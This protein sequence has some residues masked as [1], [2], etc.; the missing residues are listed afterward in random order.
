M[1]TRSFFVLVGLMLAAVFSQCQ[2]STHPTVAYSTYLS[3]DD[4]TEIVASTADANGYQYVLGWTTAADFPTT[5]NAYRR[6]PSPAAGCNLKTSCQFQTMFVSKFSRDGRSLVYSTF[7]A[8]AAPGSIAI[9][10][11]GNVYGVAQPVSGGD[12]TATPGA[13]QTSCGGSC[14]FLFKLNSSG[15]ALVYSTYLQGANYCSEQVGGGEFGLGISGP[16]VAVN[17]AGQAYVVLTA[18]PGCFTT[19]GAFKPKMLSG[20]NAIVMKFTADGSGVLY[21]TYVGQYNYNANDIGETIAVDSNDHAVIAG[22]TSSADFPT[23]GHAFQRTRKGF[24]DAFVAKLSADGSALLASTLLGGASATVAPDQANPSSVGGS[25]AVDPFNNVYVAGMT[26]T[27][28]FPVS[29]TAPEHTPDPGICGPDNDRGPCGDAFLAKL[30]PDFSQLTYSTFLGGPN[31]EEAF[32][33]VAVDKVGHAFVNGTSE[34]SQVPLVKPTSS[35]GLA[36]L[37]ELNTSGTQFLFSTRY[38]SAN[39]LPRGIGVDLASN[40]Y[41]GG[42]QAASDLPTTAHAYQTTDMSATGRAGFAAKWDI[43]PCTLSSND[44]YVTICTPATNGATVPDHMLLS[45]GATDSHPV[46]AMK[47]YVDGNA[48]F[49]IAATHFNTYVNLTSGKHR[50]Q[51]KAWDSQGQF[52]TTFYVTAQ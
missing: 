10:S 43:P 48:V 49:S 27:T 34:S 26:N 15:S 31:G 24:F 2:T 21:S 25:V 19:S 28:D 36:W 51:V 13:W 14:N 33:R 18:G 5:S 40:A 6:T 37:A 20:W 42:V 9:D 7:I 12:M 4:T 17:G 46:S 47:V 32:V 35:T 38:G 50:I 16:E 39:T 1:Y 41:A 3:G 11:S 44:P 8:N 30:P 22:Y 52:A 45:A 23:S 29:P